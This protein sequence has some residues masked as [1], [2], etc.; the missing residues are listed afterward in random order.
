ML[1]FNLTT[2]HL[3]GR[4][5]EKFPEARAI[6]YVDDTYIKVKL[7]VVLQDLPDL[8]RVLK[9]DVDLELNVSRPPSSPRES[10]NR[11]L[12]M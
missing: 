1:I 6:G 9:E 5:L 7:S 12:S 2:L 4:V 11:L 10:P 3:W 8:K